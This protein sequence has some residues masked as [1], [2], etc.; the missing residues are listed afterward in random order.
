MTTTLVPHWTF[1]DR[2]RKAREAAGVSV[3]V[4]AERTGKSARAVRSWEA[5]DRVPAGGE[6][7]L[8]EIYAE[9]TGVPFD[10]IVGAGE[11]RTGSR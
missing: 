2:L 10:W 3:E 8:A 7:A 4:I 1:G 6:L 9:L 11:F 5:D